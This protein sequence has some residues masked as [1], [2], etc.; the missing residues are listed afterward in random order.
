MGAFS[1]NAVVRLDPTTGTILSSFA[2]SGAR[3][4]FQLENG[5]ILWTNSSG[6]HVY[7]V[8]TSTST[9]VYAGQGRHIGVLKM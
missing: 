1:S 4:V 8:A 5:N 2:A 9:Q 3:G 6:V 7:D